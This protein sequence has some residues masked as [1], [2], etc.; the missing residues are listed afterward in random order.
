MI[1]MS[2]TCIS[3]KTVPVPSVGTEYGAMQDIAE[4]AYWRSPTALHRR[5]AAT[6]RSTHRPALRKRAEIRCKSL[7]LSVIS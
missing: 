6:G 2:L 7:V 4:R 5:R 1:T 3:A